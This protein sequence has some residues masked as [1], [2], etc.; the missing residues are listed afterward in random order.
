MSARIKELEKALAETKSA[1]GS[2]SYPLLSDSEDRRLEDIPEGS[3][4]HWE[5]KYPSE[6]PGD[7]SDL[8]GT[9]SVALDGQRRGSAE[10]LQA[11]VRLY[12]TRHLH[13]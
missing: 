2:L 6:S 7:V 9:M 4:N 1:G 8:V 5:Q 3:G 12:P 11:E 10:I 13:G